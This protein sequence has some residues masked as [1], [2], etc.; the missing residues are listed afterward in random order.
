MFTHIYNLWQKTKHKYYSSS[1]HRS[2]IWPVYIFFNWLRVE[3]RLKL[4]P[5]NFK[6]LKWMF[7]VDCIYRALKSMCS[8]LLNH[9]SPVHIM[10]EYNM[11]QSIVWML[12]KNQYIPPALYLFFSISD[13]FYQFHYRWRSVCSKSALTHSII[14]SFPK[15]KNLIWKQ[16]FNDIWQLQQQGQRPIISTILFI[17]I[18]IKTGL[19]YFYLYKCRLKW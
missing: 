8:L 18:F 19:H 14:C 1:S 4:F 7:N 13:L 5:R 15:K 12:F 16:L 11:R 17:Y 9:F 3:K 2:I 10:Y 6:T